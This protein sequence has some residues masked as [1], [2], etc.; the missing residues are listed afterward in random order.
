MNLPATYCNPLPMPDYQRGAKSFNKKHDNTISWQHDVRHDFRQAA[1]PTAVRFKGQWYLFT[2]SSMFWY[3]D[4]MLNWTF[5]RL[6]LA[7]LG[8]SGG[9]AP[10]AVAKDGYLYLVAAW[11]DKIWRTKEPLGEWELLGTLTDPNGQPV[12]MGDPML[13]LDDDGTM[14]CYHGLGKDGI[15]VAKVNSDDMTKLT[16][17]VH[18]FG[19]NPDHV[20][21][22]YGD[23]NE[24]PRLSYIEGAWMTKHAGRYYLQYSA[25]GTQWKNYAVG[26]YIGESPT[27]PWRYQRRNPILIAPP[28][29]FVNGCG[30]HSVVE[31][32]DGNLWVFYTVS[33]RIENKSERR[34]GMDPVYFDEAGEMFVAGPT[35]TP[36][37]A[38]G[39]RPET[40]KGNDLGLLPVSV[41]KIV[42][43]SSYAPG[44]EPVYAVDDNIR[45]WWEAEGS[46]MPQWIEVD[47]R[48]DFLVSAARTM[49][50]DRGLDYDAGITPGPYGYR[51]EGSVDAKSWFPLVDRSTNTVDRHIAYDVWPATSARW[52]RLVA[53]SAPEG[54]RT[55]LWEF[56][57]FGT[58]T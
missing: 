43:A 24:D 13:F 25:N 30:H 54:M 10:T 49:F 15:Y 52:I 58:A 33:V 19:F 48:G 29:S 20:W 18:C 4:D 55:S 12:R 45:T 37:F 6:A 46:S 56:T 9:C 7:E 39:A 42:C 1:D 2:S 21:E 36:Q 11:V 34:I 14:Y 8:P 16:P 51:I 57:V 38:P 53:L 44:H 22:R 3:S 28:G 5:H 27:G 17:F 23:F 32:P 41:N 50:A 40:V 31:G 35:Q 47:L 26:C